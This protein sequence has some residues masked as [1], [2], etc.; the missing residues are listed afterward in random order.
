MKKS[1]LI[2]LLL[3]AALMVSCRFGTYEKSVVKEKHYIPP[4]SVMYWSPTF[5]IPRTHTDPEE[6]ALI[7]DSAGLTHRYTVSKEFYENVEVGDSVRYDD[8]SRQLIIF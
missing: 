8:Q 2:L 1:M 5:K 3:A 6:Y 7:L 4:R